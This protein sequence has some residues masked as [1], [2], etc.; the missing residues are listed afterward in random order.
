MIFDKHIFV[1]IN[2]RNENAKRIS[3]GE[4]TGTA[5]ANRF[6]E[7]IKKNRLKTKVRSQR[8][9]CLDICEQGPTMVVYPEGIFYKNV[10]LED[11]DEIFEQHI[12]NNIVV[13]RLQVKFNKK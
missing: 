3:C 7:L 2:E 6:K 10:Q 4:T 11:V 12:V 9:S 13:E 1:C 5:I 8:S